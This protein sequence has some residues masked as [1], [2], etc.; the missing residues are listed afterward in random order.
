[1]QAL[2]PPLVRRKHKAGP[3]DGFSAVWGIKGVTILEGNPVSLWKSEELLSCSGFRCCCCF[4]SAAQSV[5]TSDMT[6]FSQ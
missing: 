5:H 2:S 1:M 6:E 3:K 4:L